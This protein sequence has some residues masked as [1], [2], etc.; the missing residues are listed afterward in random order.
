MDY[1]IVG[2]MPQGFRGVGDQAEAWVPTASPIGN[3]QGFFRERA[4]RGID[5]LGRLRDGV[6]LSAAQAEMDNISRALVAIT[7]ALHYA[8]ANLHETLSSNSAKTT[9][10]RSSKRFA[11]PSLWQR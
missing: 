3:G 1:K 10:A 9:A 7:H 5:V 11:M 4:T 6:S 8:P 2:V